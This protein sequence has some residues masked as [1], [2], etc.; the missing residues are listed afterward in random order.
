[1]ALRRCLEAETRPFAEYDPPSRAPQGG[2]KPVLKRRAQ[3][4]KRTP[5]FCR[6]FGILQEGSAEPLA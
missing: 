1:M 6:T 3:A 2:K 5:E 4:P